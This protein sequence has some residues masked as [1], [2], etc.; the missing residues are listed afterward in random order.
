MY[1]IRKLIFCVFLFTLTACGSD[2]D[3]GKS[4]V[5]GISPDYPPFESMRDGEVVGFDV[6]LVT[7]IAGRMNKELVI[8]EMEFGSLIP[9][10]NTNKIDIAIS[11][12]TKNSNRSKNVGFSDPYFQVSL[13]AV[14]K[15][16]EPVESEEAMHGKRVGVQTGS[17]LE[18]YAK[19]IP[20][21]NIVSMDNNLQLIQ[22]LLLNRI[23]VM[24]CENSQAPEFIKNNDLSYTTFGELGAQYSIAFKKGNPLIK[25]INKT[26]HQLQ[27]E[28]ILKQLNEKWISK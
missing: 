25:D 5:V 1:I 24:L 7:Y 22:E 19:S 12:L 28:G 14:F 2:I 6:D 10:L 4:L 15:K 17:T 27:S 21:V 11:G 23:D 20:N 3:K 26:L 16:S 13:A 8:K 18:E 9:S